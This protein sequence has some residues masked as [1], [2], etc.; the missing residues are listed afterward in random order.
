MLI[1]S[2]FNGRSNSRYSEK[3]SPYGAAKSLLMPSHSGKL[4]AQNG[5]S[6]RLCFF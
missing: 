3:A 1:L 5:V 4:T 6:R 2:G